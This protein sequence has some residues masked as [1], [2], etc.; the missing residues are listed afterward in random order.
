[1]RADRADRA[2]V[3][4]HA[5]ARRCGDRVVAGVRRDPDPRQTVALPTVTSPAYVKIVRYPDTKLNLTYFSTLTSTNGTDWTPVL[6]STVAIDMG[7]G[8]YLAGV[9]GTGANG[10]TSPASF[11]NINFDGRNRAA[12]GCLR[13][14]VHVRRRRDRRRH[15][16]TIVLNDPWTMQASGSDIWATTTPSTSSTRTSRTIPRTPSTATAR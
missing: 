15:P 5:Q 2:D 13:R 9:V 6:G 8:P 16:A 11:D 3:R 10:A 12:G 14:R 7:P 4:R 1:M